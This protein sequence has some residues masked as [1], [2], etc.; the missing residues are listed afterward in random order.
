MTRLIILAALLTAC[1]IIPEDEFHC[2][3]FLPHSNAHKNKRP[4]LENIY[5]Q[6]R[7]AESQYYLG[8]K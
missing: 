6:C 1:E 5:R 8:S 2:E 3:R 7:E 4:E